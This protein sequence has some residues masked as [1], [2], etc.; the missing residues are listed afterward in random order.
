MNPSRSRRPRS[1]CPTRRL[2]RSLHTT[3]FAWW[4]RATGSAEC[5]P[6]PS[7]PLRPPRRRSA[8]PG[9]PPPRHG[10]SS[11]VGARRRA[12]DAYAR[13]ALDVVRLQLRF[14]T[15]RAYRTQLLRGGR[16]AVYANAAT[17][18]RAAGA[19]A[20]PTCLPLPRLVHR[21]ASPRWAPFG[22]FCDVGVGTGLL[23][24]RLLGA[25]S[26]TGIGFDISLVH[27]CA[28]SCPGVRGRGALPGRAARRRGRPAQPPGWLVS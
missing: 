12:V 10:S 18:K 1:A 26:M 28:S 14:E 27:F 20:V 23:A 8:T 24:R 6:R 4:S 19:D 7:L 11:L 16:D 3:W 5:G 21:R 15:E 9:S 2:P 17:W 13:F 22:Q 25:P